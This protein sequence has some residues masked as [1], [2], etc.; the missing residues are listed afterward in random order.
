MF[1]DFSNFFS[2]FCLFSI[3][4]L[5]A[6]KSLDGELDSL[7]VQVIN[8][9]VLR[10]ILPVAAGSFGPWED[11]LPMMMQQQFAEMCTTA[12]HAMQQGLHAKDV[13]IGA[14]PADLSAWMEDLSLRALPPPPHPP[15]PGWWRQILQAWIR[16]SI[17]FLIRRRCCDALSRS[18][19]HAGVHWH[20]DDRRIWW[21]DPMQME[22]IELYYDPE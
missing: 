11:I 17:N 16:R 6:W 10:R 19:G 1:T 5:E 22:P 2:F 20:L 12:L 13:L 8:T 21:T 18:P 4:E 14:L 9:C 3:D 7:E 15:P